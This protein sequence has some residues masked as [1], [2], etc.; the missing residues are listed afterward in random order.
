MFDEGTR[1]RVNLG[2]RSVQASREETLRQARLERE[3]RELIKRQNDAA[4]LIQSRWRAHQSHLRHLSLDPVLAELQRLQPLT[5]QPL[6]AGNLSSLISVCQSTITLRRLH[7]RRLFRRPAQLTDSY[8]WL[9]LSRHHSATW[10]SLYRTVLP[11]LKMDPG[12]H[13][14]VLNSPTTCKLFTQLLLM[15]LRDLTFGDILCGNGLLETPATDPQTVMLPLLLL[16]TDPTQWTDASPEQAK[17]VSL[18]ITAE[19]LTIFSF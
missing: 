19:D 8:R 6:D 18:R 7:H 5:A 11:T 16:S 10:L 1:R 14:A 15:A 3:K 12:V 2:G 13:H 4:T 9:A 17:S